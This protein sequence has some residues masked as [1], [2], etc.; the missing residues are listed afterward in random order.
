MSGLIDI[1]PLI[2][3][4]VAVWPGDVP[5]SREVALSFAAGHNLELSAIRS[6]VHVGAHTDAPNH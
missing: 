6:T 5:F 3:P 4:G 2:H 1:S